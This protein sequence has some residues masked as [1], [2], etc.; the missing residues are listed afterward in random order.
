MA[1]SKHLLV[2]KLCDYQAHATDSVQ[3]CHLK[4]L[5]TLCFFRNSIT[6]KDCHDMTENIPQIRE[7]KLAVKFQ[8]MW[9]F[10]SN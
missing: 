2:L 8:R 3:V 10:T 7:L 4:E 6:S 5:H 1:L 9:I